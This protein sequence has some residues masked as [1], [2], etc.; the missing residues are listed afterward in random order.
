MSKSSFDAFCRSITDLF[1]SHWSVCLHILSLSSV[2]SLRVD[3][4]PT[5]SFIHSFVHFFF[6]RRSTNRPF[7]YIFSHT[8]IHS[9]HSTIVFLSCNTTVNYDKLFFYSE[10]TNKNFNIEIEMAV[11]IV[12]SGRQRFRELRQCMQN[13]EDENPGNT[14]TPDSQVFYF[15]SFIFFCLF[16][17]FCVFFCVPISQRKMRKQRILFH[18]C[19]CVKYFEY[20]LLVISTLRS[21]QHEIS[22]L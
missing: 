8:F 5:R 21:I 19:V 10:Q 3:R 7:T 22:Q 11:K 6:S 4:F 20:F 1:N 15:Y 18:F 14:L 17:K 16:F 13:D 9:S 12:Q 2:C